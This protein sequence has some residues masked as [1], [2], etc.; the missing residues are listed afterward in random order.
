MR[1]RGEGCSTSSSRANHEIGQRIF[2][3][4]FVLEMGDEFP[5]TV[6]L[7][8]TDAPAFSSTVSTAL[9]EVDT[10][11]NGDGVEDHGVTEH[12]WVFF[13]REGEG[14]LND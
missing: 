14:C 10:A 13:Y 12:R 7:V 2:R 4:D 5:H 8:V 1:G 6:S 9:A 11:P 3:G